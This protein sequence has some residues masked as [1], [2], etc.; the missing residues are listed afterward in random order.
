MG[1]VR[2]LM[3]GSILLMSFCVNGIEAGEPAL[4]E[5]TLIVG[6]REAPPFAMKTR[7]GIWAGIGIDLWRQIAAE[8]GL[9]FELRELDL[10]SLLG[11]VANGSLDAAVAALTITSE[12]EKV[13]DF[14]HPFYTTGLG[15][16]VASKGGSPW[17]TVLKGFMSL[18][19]LKIVATLVLLLLVVGALVWWFERGRNV[20]QFGGSPSEGIGAGFWWSAVTMTTVGYGDKAPVT[21]GGR[22]VALIWMFA[23]IIIISG[24]TAAITSSLTVT[25]LESPVRGPEDLPEVRVGSIADT[26]SAS[27]LQD[28]QILFRPYTRSLEGLGAVTGGEIDAF[29]YDAP[30]LR[31]LVNRQF[32]GRLEVL[33][34]TFDRQDYGIALAPGSPLREPINRVLLQ[35]IREPGW[36]EML[37]RYM[38]R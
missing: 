24:F 36:Q 6:T 28:R 18:A 25:Q 15:I 10:K 16:A 27:Y 1:L 32:R 14:T 8:L 29:V 7:E 5:R 13:L 3:M 4:S 38:G 37:Y 26:T 20:K 35:K 11:G 12:R 30:L 17:V 19:F 22:I 34:N 23:A 21:L 9:K 31:Y 33:N 2:S